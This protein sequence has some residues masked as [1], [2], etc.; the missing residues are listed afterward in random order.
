MD[1]LRQRLSYCP[2]CTAD[3]RMAQEIARTFV[4]PTA[5]PVCGSDSILSAFPN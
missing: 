1:E 5:C 4:R 2:D 3:I